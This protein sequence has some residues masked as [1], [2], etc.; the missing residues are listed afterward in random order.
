MIFG[1]GNGEKGVKIWNPGG[2]GNRTGRSTVSEKL[3]LSCSPGRLPDQEKG[4]EGPEAR[5]GRRGF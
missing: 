5:A 1:L 2:D 3:E 4:C